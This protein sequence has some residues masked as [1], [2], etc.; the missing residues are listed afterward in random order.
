[1][2]KAKCTTLLALPIFAAL[3]VTPANADTIVIYG[4]SGKIG[5]KIVTEA[6]DRE[7]KVIGVSRNPES[8][9][10]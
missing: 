10:I 6:L 2:N 3:A 1:M 5:S 8:L 9:D 4:A 7:H